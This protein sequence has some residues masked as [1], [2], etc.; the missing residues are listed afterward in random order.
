[1][2]PT[3]AISHGKKRAGSSLLIALL[4]LAVLSIVGTT[5]LM[6][7]SSRYGGTR[8]SIQ[9]QGALAI[10]EAGAD[11]GWQTAGGRSMEIRLPGQ[12]GRSSGANTWTTVASTAD[13]T[14]ELA[15]G[16]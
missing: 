4:T 3:P 13:A 1:M 16:L 15:A 11:F 8:Q 5:V 7:L 14:A 9:W 10:A 6:N 2:K 12:N